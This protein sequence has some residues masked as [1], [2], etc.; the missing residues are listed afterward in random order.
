[1]TCK[2]CWRFISCDR[3]LIQMRNK[4]LGNRSESCPWFIH[5]SQVEIL[6]CN[7]GD[8]AYIYE[9]NKLY[10]GEVIEIKIR[11]EAENFSKFISR[12]I[13]VAFR[14]LGNRTYDFSDINEKLF[15][16]KPDKHDN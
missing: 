15:L 1:M 8:Q 6:P 16:I 11:H 9:N 12:K 2:D 7:I 10:T 13:V 4:F 14:T 3:Y 5:Q